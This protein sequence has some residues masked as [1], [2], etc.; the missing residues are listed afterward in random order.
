ML[1]HSLRPVACFCPI[2]TF[3]PSRRVRSPTNSALSHQS[4][5][6]PRA[7]SACLQIR[8][9]ISAT[10]HGC[11]HRSSPK[12][13]RLAG[14]SGGDGGR[15]SPEHL[16]QSA[17]CS[18]PRPR[19]LNDRERGI[20][21]RVARGS[22]IER[23]P[24]APAFRFALCNAVQGCRPAQP[25]CVRLLTGRSRTVPKFCEFLRSAFGEKGAH[26]E[27][28][29]HARVRAR[30]AF[31][32]ERQNIFLE[33]AS[34]RFQTGV[35]RSKLQATSGPDHSGF[36]TKNSGS[37]LTR[38]KCDSPRKLWKWCKAHPQEYW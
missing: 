18:A 16:A 24:A 27:L 4:A 32:S 26:L 29:F 20:S 33:R 15:R 14:R 22:T 5:S 10:R 30:V 13:S 19:H 36:G 3:A 31:H 28:R 25:L 2:A 17:Q 12:G 34:N 7:A 21:S 38:A 23:Q 35:S 1:A 11:N 8:V 6:A 9:G 37:E